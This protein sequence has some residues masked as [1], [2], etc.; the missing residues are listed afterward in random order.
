MI[1]RFYE[2][3][4]T[5]R[6]LQAYVMK[7][8]ESARNEEHKIEIIIDCAKNAGVEVQVEEFYGYVR[9]GKEKITQGQYA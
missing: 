7:T 3:L 8:I 2:K 1:E 4:D 6:N 5:D 9:A